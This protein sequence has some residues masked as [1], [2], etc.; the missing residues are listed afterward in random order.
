MV[1]RVLGVVPGVLGVVHRV[2]G[3]VPRVPGVVPVPPAPIALAQGYLEAT[4]PIEFQ[5]RP[6]YP[7]LNPNQD[8]VLGPSRR[9]FVSLVSVSMRL[10][11]FFRFP[12]CLCFSACHGPSGAEMS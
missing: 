10:F 11:V 12:P 2:L 1:P 5:V 4:E 6:P 3:V 8:W 9:G 7:Y